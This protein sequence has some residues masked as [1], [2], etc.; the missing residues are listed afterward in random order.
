MMQYLRYKQ[1]QNKYDNINTFTLRADDIYP[2]VCSLQW[3][4][5]YNL[6]I[7]EKSVH[8]FTPPGTSLH[9]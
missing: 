9:S 1:E 5:F 6:D 7:S 2:T 4:L 8:V 3:V